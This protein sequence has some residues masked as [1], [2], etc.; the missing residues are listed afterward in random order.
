MRLGCCGK[1]ATMVLSG[2]ILEQVRGRDSEVLGVATSSRLTIYEL[3][4]RLAGAPRHERCKRELQRSDS[5][6]V[7]A[8]ALIKPIFRRLLVPAR[9]D[10]RRG[11]RGDDRRFDS[12]RAA[13]SRTGRF[14]YR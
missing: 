5:L 9:C 11:R 14:S 12:Q 7:F 8:N 13:V 4:V 1:T 6:R 2:N 10:G 3:F